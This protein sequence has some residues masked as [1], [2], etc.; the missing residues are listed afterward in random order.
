MTDVDER[1]PLTLSGLQM[2]LRN[3]G[4][5]AGVLPCH[6]HRFRGTFALWRL[7][8]G[9]DVHSLRLLMGHSSLAVLQKVPGLG[10]GDHGESTQG[11]LASGQPATQLP[12]KMK[13]PIQ[14][15]DS[16]PILKL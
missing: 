12:Q 15:R 11:A 8:D 4:E 3:F 10:G 6:P 5:K 16:P 2:V 13:R 9:I 1:G 14:Q 7:R